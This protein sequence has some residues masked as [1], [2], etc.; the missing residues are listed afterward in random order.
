[1]TR[2]LIKKCIDCGKSLKHV[3]HHFRCNNCWYKNKEKICLMEIDITKIKLKPL[4][5]PR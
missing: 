3:S 5:N 4:R 1:M 2:P